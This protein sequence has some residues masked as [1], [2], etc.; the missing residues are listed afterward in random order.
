MSQ[1]W[2]DS[3]IWG[4]SFLDVFPGRVVVKNA[5]LDV[6][7]DAQLGVA[8]SRKGSRI[9]IHNDITE[10]EGKHTGLAMNSIQSISV[11]LRAK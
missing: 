9:R 6:A 4:W 5:A 10:G 1:Q 2:I 3:W 11:T 7:L 8:V